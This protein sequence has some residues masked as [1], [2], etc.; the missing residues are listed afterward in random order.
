MSG[1]QQRYALCNKPSGWAA[2]PASI[3][4]WPGIHHADY[5]CKQEGAHR[6]QHSRRSALSQSNQPPAD[7]LLVGILSRSSQ[8]RILTINKGPTALTIAHFDT[9]LVWDPSHSSSLQ[10]GRDAPFTKQSARRIEP[11]VTPATSS[12]PVGVLSGY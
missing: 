3:H 11:V 9:Q 4:S 10:P 2:V 8:Y 12:S 6:S 7:R 1:Y 5:H